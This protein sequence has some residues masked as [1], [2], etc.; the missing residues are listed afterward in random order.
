[1]FCQRLTYAVAGLTVL[2]TLTASNIL[3]HSAFVVEQGGNDFA[4]LKTAKTD[5]CNQRI[6]RIRS[7]QCCDDREEN[8]VSRSMQ[9]VNY[10]KQ[11]R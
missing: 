2:E 6:T 9:R 4:A 1:V 7:Q 11:Q 5:E 8:K 3:H 10:F